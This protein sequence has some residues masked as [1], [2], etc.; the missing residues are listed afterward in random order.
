MARSGFSNC[1]NSGKVCIDGDAAATSP[2]L[3]PRVFD[4]TGT[5]APT[6]AV[7]LRCRQ[8][9]QPFGILFEQLLQILKHSIFFDRAR[10]IG[11][12]E[13]LAQV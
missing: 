11:E 6:Q 2:E 5:D 9:R 4:P 7:R 3:S 12:K 13:L 10:A 1:R 8:G